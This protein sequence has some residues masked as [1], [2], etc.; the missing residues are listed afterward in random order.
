MMMMM[1]I[2]ILILIISL[3]YNNGTQNSS[4]DFVIMVLSVIYDYNIYVCVILNCNYESCSSQ[5]ISNSWVS[6][7]ADWEI[8]NAAGFLAL[9]AN[10]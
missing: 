7:E 9:E 3:N 5:T 10:V 2:L 6:I 8:G 1:M 4:Y